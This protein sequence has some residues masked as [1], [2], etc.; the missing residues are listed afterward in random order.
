MFISYEDLK[1]LVEKTLKAI[2]ESLGL[3]YRRN[4]RC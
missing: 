2:D 4:F 1:V 3:I